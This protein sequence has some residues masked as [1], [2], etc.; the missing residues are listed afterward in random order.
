MTDT[1]WTAGPCQ[2]L[3]ARTGSLRDMDKAALRK[4]GIL[5]V[6]TGDP[7]NV[8]LMT[9]TPPILRADQ[10]MAAAGKAILKSATAAE[11]FGAEMARTMANPTREGQDNG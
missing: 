4:A 1:K 6:E 5:I 11:Y 9:A 10:V 3:I 7:E 2:I 8:R